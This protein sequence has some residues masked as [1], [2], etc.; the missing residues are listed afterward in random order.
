VAAVTVV[1][2]QTLGRAVHGLWGAVLDDQAFETGERPASI[3]AGGAAVVVEAPLGLQG[4]IVSAAVVHPDRGSGAVAGPDYRTTP[5]Q[6]RDRD[7]AQQPVG[8]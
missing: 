2:E 3:R 8:D 1:I 7:R 4:G 5:G 6:G